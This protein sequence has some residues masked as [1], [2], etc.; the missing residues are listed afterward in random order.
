M[1]IH[2]WMYILRQYCSRGMTASLKTFS[3]KSLAYIYYD[4]F[5]IYVY[6]Y[7]NIPLTLAVEKFYSTISDE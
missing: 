7:F 4:I 2:N 6:I 5:H 1:S 3:F